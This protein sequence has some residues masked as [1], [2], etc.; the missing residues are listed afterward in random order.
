MEQYRRSRWVCPV[1]GLE[2]TCDNP[3]DVFEDN[4]PWPNNPN[5]ILYVGE[6]V[7]GV[8]VGSASSGNRKGG[9]G[10]PPADNLKVDW[11]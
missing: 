10:K 6:Q 4:V 1:V 5:G 7:A 2:E 3:F 9:A 8:V 11:K